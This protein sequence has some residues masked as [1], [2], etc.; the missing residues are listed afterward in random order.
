MSTAIGSSVRALIPS[1]AYVDA[2]KAITFLCEAFGFEK[3]AVYEGA[4][5]TIEHAQLKLGEFFIM[6]GTAG[7]NAE[8]PSKSPRELGGATTGGLYVVLENDA[9]VDAHFEQ[10]RKAGADIIREPRSPEYGGRDYSARD[11]EG[12]L[13]SFGSYRPEMAP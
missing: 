10:A 7:K 9:A 13:W 6:L 11:T 12:Y 3:H 8:W 4:P 2:P 5:G 1:F